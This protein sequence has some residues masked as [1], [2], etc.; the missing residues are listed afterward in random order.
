MITTTIHSNDFPTQCCVNAYTGNV[1]YVII[2]HI[3][4][5][6]FMIGF[7]HM[8]S[9]IGCVLQVMAVEMTALSYH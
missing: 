4:T 2:T 9:F 6:N 5:D 3:I 8:V 7:K 1:L